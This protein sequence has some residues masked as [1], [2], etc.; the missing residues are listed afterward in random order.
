MKYADTPYVAEKYKNDFIG[1]YFRESMT[2]IPT[3]AESWSVL[4]L[5]STRLYLL[6]VNSHLPHAE[7]ILLVTGPDFIILSFSKLPPL[8]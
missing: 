5:E 4:F 8:L 6:Q 2:S 1:K 7:K 3:H